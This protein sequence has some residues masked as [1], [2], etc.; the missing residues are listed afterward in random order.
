MT[1]E[2]TDLPMDLVS[3]SHVVPW[4]CEATIFDVETGLRM[5]TVATVKMLLMDRE[6]SRE[7]FCP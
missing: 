1:T 6:G 5:K 7:C 4:T 2:N 3:L